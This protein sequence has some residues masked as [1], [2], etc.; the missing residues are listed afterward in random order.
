MNSLQQM[1]YFKINVTE[2][3]LQTKQFIFFCYKKCF[4]KNHTQIHH[5]L[6]LRKFNSNQVL[7]FQVYLDIDIK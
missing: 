3:F 6:P 1:K 5:F 7:Y 2:G 4:L